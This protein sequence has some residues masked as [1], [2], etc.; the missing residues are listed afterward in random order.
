VLNFEIA[1]FLENEIGN[2]DW[3]FPYM[4]DGCSYISR[5]NQGRKT[6]SFGELFGTV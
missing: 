5:T 2:D 6:P 1:Y 3:Q 4:R